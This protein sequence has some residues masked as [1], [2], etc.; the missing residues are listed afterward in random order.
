MAIS[1]HLLLKMCLY[2]H[3]LNKEVVFVLSVLWVN[4]RYP[5]NEY[6]GIQYILY[7]QNPLAW[8]TVCRR[9]QRPE[10][11]QRHIFVRLKRNVL[12]LHNLPVEPFWFGY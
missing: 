8:L 7:T 3:V 2:M 9:Q 12:S 6:C 1:S 11:A 10:A 5:F 4:T